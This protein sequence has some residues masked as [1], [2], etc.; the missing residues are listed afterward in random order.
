LQDIAR[1]AQRLEKAQ[2]Q[3][4]SGRRINVV[5]DSPDEISQL[6]ATRSQLASTEQIHGNLNRVKGEVDAAESALEQAVNVMDRIAVLGAQGATGTISAD[7]RMSL[8]NELGSLL[9]QLVNI[10]ATRMD[11]R[12]VF[13]GDAD[14]TPPYTA[15]LGTD[16]PY[17]PYQG[18]AS[19]RRIEHPS[20]ARIQVSLTAE[21]IFEDPDPN[22]NV[23]DAVNDLRNALLANDVDLI[24]DALGRVSHSNTHLN[25]KLAFYGAAQTRWPRVWMLHSSRSCG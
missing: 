2:T 1:I 17:S 22:Q 3:I 11:G 6:L 25:N 10:A 4:T 14:T 13:S 20:G 8:A 9:E 15:D 19:S 7:N 18:A 12:F 24:K 5:S 16:P 21:E 23:F